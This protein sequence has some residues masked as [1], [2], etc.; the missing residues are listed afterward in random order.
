MSD[1][2]AT[3][4]IHESAFSES[5]R[6]LAL[7]TLLSLLLLAPF[8]TGVG[9]VQA[10]ESEQN[11]PDFSGYWLRPEAGNGRMFYPPDNGLGP[12]VN[13]DETRTFTIGDHTSQ[14]LLP[15]AAEAVK[16][17]GDQGRAGQVIYPAW[18]LC[19]PP[20][21]PLALNMAEPVQILQNNDQ[22]MILYQ[23]GYQYRQIDL[24]VEHPENPEPSWFGHSVGHYEGEDTLVIDTIAQDSR[25]LIDRFGTPKSDALRVVERYTISADR[26][27]LNIAFEVEDPKTFTTSWSA[28]I[29]YVRPTSRPGYDPEGFNRDGEAIAENICAE[30]NRDAAGGLFEI[31][32]AARDDF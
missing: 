6:V 14:I 26:Q 9:L 20:G 17:H 16:A 21:V 10:A 30:N 31:P 28:K 4:K 23:R 13:I 3:I 19:W 24:N 2:Q 11:N 25:S 5:P 7:C 12:L 18:S 1:R 29:A 27:T 22:V 32:Y 8:A 15:H